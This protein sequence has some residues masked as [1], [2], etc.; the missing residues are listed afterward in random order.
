MGRD[1]ALIEVD[2]VTLV[3]RAAMALRSAGLEPVVVVGG[4]QPALRSLGLDAVADHH[5]G[6]G[7][8]GGVITALEVLDG[9]PVVVLACDLVEAS[10]VAIGSVVGALGDADLAIP[11]VEG[12]HQWLHAA[13]RHRALPHLRQRFAEGARSVRDGAEGLRTTLLLDGDPCW[14]HDADTPD[15]LPPA[16]HR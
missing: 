16:A 15:D 7:P 6:E 10:P 11:V 9:D 14:Y 5:P 2:G 13:W 1:K 4:E 12:R 8:L 3:E